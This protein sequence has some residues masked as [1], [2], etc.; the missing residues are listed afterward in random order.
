MGNCTGYCITDANEENGK[1]KITVE[2]AFSNPN[3]AYL[4][5]QTAA[6]GAQEFE[7]EYGGKYDI[8]SNK[9]KTDLMRA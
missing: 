8:N 3:G 7:I 2:N 6:D 9:N 4:T 1:K 5:T